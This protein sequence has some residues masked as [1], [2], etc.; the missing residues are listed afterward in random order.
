MTNYPTTLDSFQNPG[1][2]TT[3]DAS[4]FEHDLQHANANDSIAALE[5]KV[6]VTG[7]TDVNSLDY[8]VGQL[9]ALVFPAN[10]TAKFV[11]SNGQVLL[12]LWD[13]GLQQYC[14]LLLN[15]GHLGV[16]APIS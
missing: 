11:V 6:G 16:G 1:A 5:I 3:Q 7:S 2:S 13:A 8:K 15:N 4:G 12:A 14:P 10:G 9:N